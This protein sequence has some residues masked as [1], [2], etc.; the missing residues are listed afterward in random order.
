MLSLDLDLI[1]ESLG[2]LNFKMPRLK[3]PSFFIS[4]KSGTN[5]HLAFL[6]FGLDTIAF[7]RNPILALNFISYSL[8]CKYYLF[9]FVFIISLILCFPLF[10]VTFMLPLN[11]GRLSIVYELK[12]KARVIGITDQ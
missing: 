12:G 9:T 1:K 10:L 11:L 5:S 8:K 2:K 3:K 7:I 6:S 4:N